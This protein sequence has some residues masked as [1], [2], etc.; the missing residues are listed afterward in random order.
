V[1]NVVLMAAACSIRDFKDKIIPFF[2]EQ[3]LRAEFADA[4]CGQAK[5]Y[6]PLIKTRLYNLC[7]ND[8]AEHIEPYHLDRDCRA[9]S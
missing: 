7:L 1:D 9:A 3:E 8:T 6:A 5:L 2:Q 4:G